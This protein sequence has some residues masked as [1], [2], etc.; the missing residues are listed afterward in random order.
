[1]LY[2]L[3]PLTWVREHIVS[4]TST[5]NLSDTTPFCLLISLTPQSG[6]WAMSNLC[7]YPSD[8][9]RSKWLISVIQR[10]IRVSPQTSGRIRWNSSATPKATTATQRPSNPLAIKRLEAQSVARRALLENS[11]VSVLYPRIRTDALTES[12]TFLRE[13]YSSIESSTNLKD[14][15]VTIRGEYLLEE[16]FIC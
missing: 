15:I 6:F 11:D 12:L 8:M 13:K 1:M 10:N 5:H 2:V 9:N 7:I 14:T 4:V 16:K 3:V